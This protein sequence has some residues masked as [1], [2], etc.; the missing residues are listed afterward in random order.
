[1]QRGDDRWVIRRPPRGDI[2]PGTHQMDREFI[3]MAALHGT[4]VPVPRMFEL[5]TDDSYIGAPFFLMELI[6]GVVVRGRVP[7]QFDS[8][9]ARRAIGFELA[10]KLAAIHAVDWEAVGLTTIARKPEAFL[11]RNLNKMQQLYD[12]VRHREVPEI[13]EVGAWL[14][15]NAPQQKDITLTHGDYKLDN[16]MLS[17]TDPEIVAVVD[18]EISTIGD[19]L[20]DVGWLLYFS[21]DGNDAEGGLDGAGVTFEAGYPSRAELAQRYAA[22]SGRD[23]G[24]LRF[25]CAMAG[26]KIAIIMEG[27]NLRF[28]QGD[29][30]DSMFAALDSGVPALAKR[31]LDIIAGDVSVGV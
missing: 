26:W 5:C 30:D 28:K 31:S 25:Y 1:V 9:Q 13:D 4:P 16:V 3:V 21:P 10:D 7:H 6:E 8:P 27:S 19:P 24:D 18:W 11:T 23:I 22:A 14:Q 20:V 29:A 15:A 12:A 17:P 2:L